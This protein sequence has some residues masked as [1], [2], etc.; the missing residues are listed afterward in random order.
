MPPPLT[1]PAQNMPSVILNRVIL[2][3]EVVTVVAHWVTVVVQWDKAPGI[4]CYVTGSI[5]AVTP[6]YCTKKKEKRN[7]DNEIFFLRKHTNGFRAVMY[8]MT[9]LFNIYCIPHAEY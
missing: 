7:S 4:H 5:S 8:I 9:F 6:K 3:Q 1:S 2:L